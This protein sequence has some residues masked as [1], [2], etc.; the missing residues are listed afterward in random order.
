MK[1]GKF[2]KISWSCRHLKQKNGFICT[3]YWH[4][5][6]V[7]LEHDSIYIQYALI[8]TLYTSNMIYN[9]ITSSSH[10]RDIKTNYSTAEGYW[11]LLEISWFYT[12]FTVK[13]KAYIVLAVF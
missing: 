12:N 11:F 8:Y 10:I 2:H 7:Q 5:Y 1:K 13:L 4:F 3:N 9:L 6:N